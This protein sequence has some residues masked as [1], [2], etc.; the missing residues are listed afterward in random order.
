MSAGG[1]AGWRRA[2]LRAQ[3]GGRAN[4]AITAANGR[5]HAI[6]QT[7]CCRLEIQTKLRED[8][9]ITERAPTR[10]FS[11]LKAPTKAFTFKTLELVGTFNKE[12]AL[13]EAFSV[14]LKTSRIF[15]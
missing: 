1:C 5:D 9:A 6:G 2:G 11:W 12:K 7:T 10:A 15:V 8:I 3:V 13:V 14:I 4:L